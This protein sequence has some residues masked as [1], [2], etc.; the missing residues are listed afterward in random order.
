MTGDARDIGEKLGMRH[1]SAS[2]SNP[3]AKYRLA[4]VQV[5]G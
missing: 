1:F 4:F 5:V 2:S 3:Q